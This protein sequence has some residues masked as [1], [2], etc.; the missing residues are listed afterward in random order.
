MICECRICEKIRDLESGN[1]LVKVQ[2][3][4]YSI[5]GTGRS[6]LN[7]CRTVVTKKTFGLWGMFVPRNV[8]FSVEGKDDDGNPTLKIYGLRPRTKA[9]KRK[10]VNFES[11]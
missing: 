4:D 11:L 5:K 8:K 7:P 10:E 9:F 6:W 3:N 1:V 2:F